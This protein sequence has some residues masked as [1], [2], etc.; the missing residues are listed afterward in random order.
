MHNRK[1]LPLTLCIFIL[2]FATTHA[3]LIDFETTPTATAPLDDSFLSTSYNLTGGGTVTFFFD[4]DNSFTFN[5]A[6]ERAVF[7]AYGPDGNDGFTNNAASTSDTANGGLGG[8]LGSFFLRQFQPGTPPPQ[9]LVD[10][11]TAQPIN[12]LHGEIWDIDG[13][14]GNTEQWQVDILDAAN[15]VLAS[16]PSPIGNSA[17]LDGLPWTFSFSGLPSGVDKVRI[18]FTGTKT[19][20]LGLA[21]NNFEPFNAI[22]EPASASAVLLTLA[23][24]TRR[25]SRR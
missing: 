9:F 4:F 17:A 5:G 20:G 21:F 1:L 13:S 12:A 2:P 16:Q 22:P 24:L 15:S 14:P 7:E 23:A 11:N 25:R 6:G 18:T 19:T 8:Q 3:Q 10:Y